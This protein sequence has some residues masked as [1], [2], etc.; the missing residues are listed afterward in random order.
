MA[1]AP[2]RVVDGKPTY[3]GRPLAEWLPEIVD[4]IVAATRPVRV[5]LFGSVGSTSWSCSPSWTTT[6][7]ACLAHAPGWRRRP[8]RR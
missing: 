8:R 6:V 7:R 4:E 5:L 3:D 2:Y 1:A